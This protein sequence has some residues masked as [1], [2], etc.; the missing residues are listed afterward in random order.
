MKIHEL[1]TQQPHFGWVFGNVAKRWEI[2]RNDRD[3]HV[4]DVLH[5]REFDPALNGG[6]Y[7][8][9]DGLVAITNITDGVPEGLAE[10]FVVLDIERRYL[11]PLA[12]AKPAQPSR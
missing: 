2:R 6:S 4:G 7:T 3:F 1:K 5:L 9:S 11:A 8:G 10:G 12:T